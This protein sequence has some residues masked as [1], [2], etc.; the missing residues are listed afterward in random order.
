MYVSAHQFITGLSAGSSSKLTLSPA[1]A[2]ASSPGFS[3]SYTLAGQP[4]TAVISGGATQLA[5]D[6][7]TLIT[8]SIDSSSSSV[9]E[10]W[11]FNGTGGDQ[12]TFAAGTNAT[13]VYYHLVE[14]AVSY[15]VAGAGQ[16]P[17]ASAEPE[18]TYEEPPPVASSSSAP[19]TATQVLGT[20][21][22]VIYAV[23]GTVASVRTTPGASGQRWAADPSASS[24][25]VSGPNSI[26]NPVLLYQ[27]YDVSVGYRIVGGGTPSQAP[28]FNATAFGSPSAVS[29]LGNATRGWFDAGSAYSFTSFL[30]GSAAKERW[31]QAGGGVSANGSQGNGLQGGLGMGVFAPD[32]TITGD[33]V[34]QYFTEIGVNDPHGG[35][36]FGTFSGT[37]DNGAVTGHVAPGPGWTDAGLS[38]DLNALANQ[39]WRF[40]N[41]TGSGAGTYSGT[42]S[43]VSVTVTGPLSENATFYVQLAIAAGASTNVAYSYPS[44][45]GTVQAGTNETLYLPPASNVTLR[46]TPSLFVYSFASWQGPGFAKPAD[47][48]VSLVVDSPT[49]VTGASS[50]YYPVVFG[51]AAA[52]L[53]VL[54][55]TA[56]LVRKRR[57]RE[58]GWA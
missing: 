56:L 53:L 5:A 11:V 41:W 33:Y 22:V 12:V 13:Y 44:G 7:G 48:S 21:P 51:I 19:V 26:A 3:A 52:A 20:A 55:A 1:A 46:A 27:Q 49:A 45:T 2:D 8:V 24:W 30:N 18:L 39:G 4:R 40:E 6:P 25:M 37:I 57:R 58:A 36:V 32:E 9:L 23:A 35:N 14:E 17:P 28:D 38:L 29:L 50:L 15:R 42:S 16:A 34:H 47:P 54:L 10:R 31:Q 43:S